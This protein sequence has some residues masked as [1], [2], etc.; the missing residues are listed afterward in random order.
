MQTVNTYETEYCHEILGGQLEGVSRIE[1]LHNYR[2][3]YIQN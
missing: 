2:S 3:R 1:F